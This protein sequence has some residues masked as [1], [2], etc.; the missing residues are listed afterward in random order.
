MCDDSA[1]VEIL[2]CDLLGQ[3]QRSGDEGS[4]GSERAVQC[5]VVQC[6]AVCSSA[7]LCS[8]VLCVYCGVHTCS[9]MLAA[10]RSME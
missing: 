2:A 1:D 3:V 10:R 4:E 8:A 9:L 7:V 5:Y 6:C